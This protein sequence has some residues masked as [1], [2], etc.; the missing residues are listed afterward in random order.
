MKQIA[1]I[2]TFVLGGALCA[3]EKHP[4]QKAAHPCVS[5]ESS[6]LG[7]GEVSEGEGSVRVYKNRLQLDQDHFALGYSHWKFDWE[8]LALLPFGDGRHTPIAEI[9]ALQATAHQRKKIDERWSYL[10]SF[11]LKSTFEKQTDDSFGFH[12]MGLGSYRLSDEHS[13]QFG[14]FT[15]YHP[16]KSLILPTI[17]YSYRE[18]SAEGW[19]VILGFPRTHIGY[20]I[21]EKR[22]VRLGVMVSQSLVRLSDESVIERGGYV[23]AKDYLSNL[24]ITYELTPSLSLS[25][26]LLYTLKRDFTIFDAD[27]NEV[28]EHTI[29]NALGANVRVVYR[30]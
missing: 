3:A 8:N 25:A 9:H 16:T 11:S 4:S 5:F 13:F 17:S 6:Y 19:Q 15:S 20:R 27:A 30:F 1:M 26:D 23:E 28:Q 21:D 12:L 14:G 2:A 22:L 24:G 18:R 10:A 7:E 29:G